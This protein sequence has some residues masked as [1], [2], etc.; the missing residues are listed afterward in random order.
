MQPQ[1]C[2]RCKKNV[3]VVFVTKYDGVEAKNE[4]LCLK[5]AKQ[6]GIKPIDDMIE[7]MGLSEEDLEDLSGQMAGAMGELE[8]LGAL[9]GGGMD[10]EDDE[11][12]AD[13][14]KTA[15]FPFM[16]RLFG[17]ANPP[18]NANPA[19]ENDRSAP[20]DKKKGGNKKKFLDGYCINLTMRAREGKLD[21]MIG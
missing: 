11:S 20:S 18:A 12:E 10:M 6:L 21:N 17:G 4:G 2:A 1:M 8:N 19:G 16:N 3:A 7:K 5:C 13:E 14:G 15:T 9:L